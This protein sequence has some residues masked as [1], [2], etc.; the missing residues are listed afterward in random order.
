[1]YMQPEL[2]KGTVYEEETL[3]GARYYPDETLESPKGELEKHENMVLF[4]LNAP[5]YLDC[6]EWTPVLSIE[7]VE[8]LMETYGFEDKQ[9]EEFL[10]TAKEF[11]DEDEQ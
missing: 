1:M 9:V 2:W 6:T 7:D 10:E 5:G 3:E 11:S 8:D 4:R